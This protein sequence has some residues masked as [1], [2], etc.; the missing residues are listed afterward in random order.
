[1]TRLLEYLPRGNTLD[2]QAWQRRHG[3]LQWTLLLHLPGLFLLGLALGHDARV[4]AYVLVPPLVCLLL[5]RLLAHRRSASFFITAGL[6]Y[7]SAALV[8]L[9]RGSIEAHFHFFIMIGFIALYQDWLPFLWNIVFTVLSHGFGSALTTNL[10]FNHPAGQTSPWVWSAIHGLAVLAACAGVVVFWKTTEDE[11]QKSLGLTEELAE[12]EISRR[13][14]TSDMLVNLARRNQSLL[15]RQLEII[16]QL[17]EQERD[18]DALGELFR[19]DHLATRIR[20]NAESLLVLSGEAPPR[21]WSEAVLLVDVVRA[22]IAETE[23]LDRVAFFLDER[24]AVLGRTVTDVT[25]LVAEL[26]ENAARFSPPEASVII[27]GQP[28][29]RSPGAYVLTIEDWGIGMPPGDL[30]AANGLLTHPHEVDLSVSQ[31]LGLHVVA[32]LAQRHGIDVSLAPTPGAGVTAVVVLPPSMFADSPGQPAAATVTVH[33]R[34]PLRQPAASAPHLAP[35][36]P[37]AAGPGR[38]DE[39]AWGGWWAPLTELGVD[40]A[41]P[42]DMAAERPEPPAV[43]L[44]RVEAAAPAVAEPQLTR[45]VPQSHLTPEL[46]REAEPA[47]AVPNSARAR[48]ALSRYQASRRS[49]RA[50]VEGDGTADGDPPDGGDSSPDGGDWS[51]DG[52]SWSPDGRDWSPDGGGRT[53]DGGGRTADGGGRTA[54][55][56][57]RT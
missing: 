11:Q 26:V 40:A 52:G 4:V 37:E 44:A 50:Q 45:R 12:A 34:G 8:G 2:E 20:R 56:G 31:R 9:S 38:G 22:A 36:R 25:H 35:V 23:D 33:Y 48:D 42:V 53:A 43:P 27:R 32:R 16:N 18:P 39:S 24:L 46:R 47:R 57:G 19:V 41:A 54:D 49:A 3:F 13:Q 1:V 14:F 10:I 17:E 30:A 28:W 51:P 55:G 7:C 29:P 6:V 15:Y 21:V 5:G